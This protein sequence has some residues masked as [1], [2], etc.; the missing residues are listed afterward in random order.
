MQN[1]GTCCLKT[2]FNMERSKRFFFVR[3]NRFNND[4]NFLDFR[5]QKIP[6]IFHLNPF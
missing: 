2:C 6:L 1:R 3:E 5:A 4:A